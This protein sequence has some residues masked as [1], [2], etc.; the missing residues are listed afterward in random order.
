MSMNHVS[1]SRSAIGKFDYIL[2]GAG[3]AGCVLANRLSEDPSTRVLLL[4]AGGQDTYPWIHVPIGLFYCIGNA[5]TDWRN[6]T[7]P[8][9]GLHGRS[10]QIARGRVI[11]GSSS[12]N[13]MIYIRGHARDYDTWL[14]LG[15]EDW[16]WSHVLPY[17]KK[18]EDF[19]GG[20]DEAHGVGGPLRV[21]QVRV[22]W[23]ALNDFREACAQVGL[24]KTD[25]FNRGY[26][27]GCGYVHVTQRRGRRWSA[28]RA[29]LRPATHR[30]NLTVLTGAL[31]TRIVIKQ[32]RAVGVEFSR[33]GV[34]CYADAQREVILSAGTFGSPQL[35]QLSGIGPGPLLQEHGLA[36]VR[37]LPGVGENL[38]DHLTAPFKA[39]LRDADTMNTRFNHPIKKALMGMQYFFLRRGPMT[40][41]APPLTGFARSD[42]L[43]ETPN[44]QFFADTLSFEK[45][46]ELPQKFPV[47]AVAICNLR[48]RSRGHVRI[49]S[50]DPEVPPAMLHNYL[51]DSDDQQVAIESIKL[52]E[53]IFN[54]PALSRYQP[55]RYMPPAGIRLDEDLLA[56]IR[57]TAST[58]SHP[59]GTCKMGNDSR[60]V[61]DARLR[62]HGLEALR[63]VDASIMPTLVSGNTNAPSIMIAEKAADMIKQDAQSLQS[64]KRAVEFVAS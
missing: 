10:V 41:G 39:K 63:V 47:I 2:V 36:V 8:E 53:R 52:L 34:P 58:A 42:P 60:A 22:R 12:I 61:V 1:S 55:A 35:L 59:V 9:P 11:G 13:G 26:A 57:S 18:S 24:P 50:A 44:L 62:V 31:T 28:S 32:A 21:E 23:Q 64:R 5:R 43:R 56:A 14:Q 3:S 54:A 15:N 27:E 38:Q 16:S 45:R 29:F 30:P 46:G 6:M 4:E 33:D 51:T 20:A 49:K 7:D 19:F 25:D 40:S 17:F 48:P 37:D